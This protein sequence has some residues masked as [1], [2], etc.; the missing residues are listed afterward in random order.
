MGH[1]ANLLIIEGPTPEVY[2]SQWR[3]NTLDSDLFWGPQHAT[4]FIRSQAPQHDGLKLLANEW[5]EGGAV[6]D[7][8]SRVL[9][10]YGGE[11]IRVHV[12]RRRLHLSLMGGLWPGWDIRWAREGVADIADY[13]GVPRVAVLTA[14]SAQSTDAE[15]V[16]EP[17]QDP[18]WLSTIVSMR[19]DGQVRYAVTDASAAELLDLGQSLLSATERN[20]VRNSLRWRDVARE[21]PT[22]GIH[23]DLDQHRL[24]FWVAEEAPALEARAKAHLGN[25]TIVDWGDRYEAHVLAGEGGLVIEEPDPQALVGD[26]QAY[27]LGS[28]STFS[29]PV[30]SIIN[31]FED[32]D[33]II[34]PKDARARSTLP[35]PH[36]RRRLLTSVLPPALVP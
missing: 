29:E 24:C 34:A 6:V 10:W 7:H 36:E 4:A 1:R 8:R 15:W 18:A 13:V 20:A 11:D 33:G 17:A 22:G 2:Y 16:F 21:F 35:P 5:T 9:L 25:W 12:P 28:S 19:R 32:S 14:A 30:S 3:A 23:F 26:L 27:L 31:R